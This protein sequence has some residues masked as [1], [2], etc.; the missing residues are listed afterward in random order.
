MSKHLLLFAGAFMLL[1][2][3]SG[4]PLDLRNAAIRTDPNLTPVEKKAVQM[5]V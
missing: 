2:G 3:A 4:A 1:G 5:L